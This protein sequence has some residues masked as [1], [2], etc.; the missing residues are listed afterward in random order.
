MLPLSALKLKRAIRRAH[1][2]AAVSVQQA[3]GELNSALEDSGK[4]LVADDEKTV[5]GYPLTGVMFTGMLTGIKTNPAVVFQS[6]A[7]DAGFTEYKR[8]ASPTGMLILRRDVAGGVIQVEYSPFLGG[9]Y[10]TFAKR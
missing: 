4:F 3:L 6:V 7:E 10:Y 1:L 2:A 5:R 8:P 9:Y